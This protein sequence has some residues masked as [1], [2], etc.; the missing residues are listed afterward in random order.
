MSVLSDP[1]LGD[2]FPAIDVS[3]A[4]D[5]DDRNKRLLLS[6]LR[7]FL[8][9]ALMV[10]TDVGSG[11]TEIAVEW[12][13]TIS[14]TPTQSPV[15]M[16]YPSAEEDVGIVCWLKG[17]SMDGDGVTVLLSSANHSGGKLTVLMP[18]PGPAS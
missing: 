9:G 11:E 15:A 10:S 5:S 6:G 13:A 16:F 3:E 14:P 2:F 7:D 8:L 1:A 18:P 17:G 12:P 4:A